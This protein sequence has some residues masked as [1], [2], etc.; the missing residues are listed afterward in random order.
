M[1]RFVATAASFAVAFV[2]IGGVST[3]SFAAD[4]PAY[5]LVPAAAVTTAN[6]LIV[7]ETVWKASGESYVARN[8]TSRPAIACAQAARKIGKVAA[9]TANGKEFS[10]DELAKCNEK[11]R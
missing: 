2:L 4:G 1:N 10:A 8:S 6:T 11:A 5:R 7:N 3:A 9:F